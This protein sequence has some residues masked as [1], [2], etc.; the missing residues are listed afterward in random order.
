[1]DILKKHHEEEQPPPSHKNTPP[2]TTN[3]NPPNPTKSNVPDFTSLTSPLSLV[4]IYVQHFPRTSLNISTH[5]H[6]LFLNTIFLSSSNPWNPSQ[7]KD[8]KV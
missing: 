4:S 2:Q 8:F 6:L 5:H 3:L 1:M 7:G